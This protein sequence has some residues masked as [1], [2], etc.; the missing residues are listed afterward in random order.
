[1]RSWLNPIWLLHR[2]LVALAFMPT[3]LVAQPVHENALKAAFVY[4]FVIFTEWPQQAFQESD[5]VNI[6]VYATSDMQQALLKLDGKS[7]GSRHIKVRPLR[8]IDIKLT[9]C[10]VLYMDSFDRQKWSSLKKLLAKTMT[11]TISDESAIGQDGAMIA[12]SLHENKIVFDINQSVARDSKLTFSSK[13]LR[14]ARTVK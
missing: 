7:A 10:H 3:L 2:M 4:N 8:N 14:L 12:L 5:S 1:M 9:Q 6:C 13:L 11:L